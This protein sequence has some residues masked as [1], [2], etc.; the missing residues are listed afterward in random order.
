MEKHYTYLKVEQDLLE[1]DAFTE[2]AETHGMMCGFICAGANEGDRHWMKTILN[3]A[4]THDPSKS[5][6]LAR[7]IELYQQSFIA[8]QDINLEIELLLPDD[9]Q[10][11]SVRAKALTQWCQGLL[12]GIAL[13]S[14]TL[15]HTDPDIQ[16]IIA[17]I[18]EIAKLDTTKIKGTEEEEQQFVELT[19]HVRMSTL[20]LHT[21]LQTP[22][23]S[24]PH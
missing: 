13:G 12:S 24:K 8:L 6:N 14:G 11:L 23:N 18:G 17:D 19:E 4:I 21:L 15:K 20:L 10:A 16:E 2:P 1:I 9:D 22:N 3:E 7:L 5:E